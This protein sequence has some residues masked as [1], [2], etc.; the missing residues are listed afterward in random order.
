MN[1]HPYHKM[2]FLA[3]P[4]L[5]EAVKGRLCKRD[6]LTRTDLIFLITTNLFF[7]EIRFS[8]ITLRER[9]KIW[10]YNY[11]IRMLQNRFNQLVQAGFLERVKAQSYAGFNAKVPALYVVT[12]TGQY[13]L[14]DLS[15]RLKETARRLDR[16]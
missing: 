8:T 5:D 13:V 12:T 2:F 15:A 1:V 6:K 9:L 11:S 16:V 3:L 10:G 14:K 4:V 7:E